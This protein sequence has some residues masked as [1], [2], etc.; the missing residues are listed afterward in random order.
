[1]GRRE[2]E[3]MRAVN[4]GKEVMAQTGRKAQGKKR[5][6]KCIP[7]INPS[8]LQFHPGSHPTS[9]NQAAEGRNGWG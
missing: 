6:G 2:K 3:N 4:R 9:R 7:Q 8:F 1:M 5:E